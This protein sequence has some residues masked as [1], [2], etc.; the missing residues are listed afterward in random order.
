LSNRK[1]PFALL[2]ATAAG[3]ACSWIVGPSPVRGD[4]D[5]CTGIIADI[6]DFSKPP[7]EIEGQNKI[8][9]GIQPMKDPVSGQL[10]L[11]VSGIA[12]Y[13]DNVIVTLGVR[14]KK[15]REH[16][17]KKDVLV[18]NHTFSYKFGPFKKYIPGGG[19]VVDAIFLITAQKEDVKAKLISDRY[20]RCSPPCKHDQGNLTQVSYSFGGLAAE[21]ESIK[22]EKDQIA[23]TRQSIMDAKTVAESVISKIESKDKGPGEAQ[24]ALRKLDEDLKAA[25]TDFNRWKADR[26]FLLF[27]NRTSQ[28]KSLS[29]HV[30]AELRARAVVAGATVQGLAADE[31]AKAATSEPPIVVRIADEVKAF[32][33]EAD[34]LDKAFEASHDAARDAPTHAPSGEAKAPASPGK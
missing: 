31:A 14:H 30:R 23:K 16:F 25:A 12:Y 15:V 29:T 24:A 6:V 19:L 5:P 34:S 18:K 10:S 28:L 32:L 11:R 20:F 7:S 2:V 17:D 4:D 22:A 13:P 9:I 26:L 27:A 1:R 21:E 8:R 33:D 3:I